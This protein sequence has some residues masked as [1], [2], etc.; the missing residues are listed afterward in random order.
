[1]TINVPSNQPTIQAGIDAASNGDTV[2]VAPGTYHEH[3]DF[4]GKAIEVKSSGGA[5]ST[6]IDGDSTGTNTGVVSFS[7]GESTSSILRGFTVQHAGQSSVGVRISDASPTITENVIKDNLFNN[8][9]GGVYAHG[10]A[11]HIISNV[12]SGNH[13]CGQT[14]GIQLHFSDALVQGNTIQ[15]NTV[16]CSGGAGGI[17]VESQASTGAHIIGNHIT[18]NSTQAQGGGILLVL[19]TTA[20]VHDNVIDHNS[21]GSPTAGFG[22]GVAWLT[23]DVP[24]SWNVSIV[25]NVIVANSAA[26][27]GGGVVLSGFTATS[28]ALLVNNTVADNA[29]SDASAAD[30]VISGAMENVNMVGNI[31]TDSLGCVRD[32]VGIPV[33]FLEQLVHGNGSVPAGRVGTN[34]NITANPHFLDAPNVDYR[35]PVRVAFG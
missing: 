34:G 11:A 33:H 13:G 7:S 4:T 9:G 6:I 28:G 24:G 14:A 31:F 30:I 15:N 27:T 18:G 22:G 19:T 12:V 10:G 5:A 23:G 8:F 21:S 17:G 29:T 16:T 35:A 3:I 20:E 1:M 32:H 26:V 25:Q 2:V